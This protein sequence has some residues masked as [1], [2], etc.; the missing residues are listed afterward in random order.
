MARVP[1]PLLSAQIRVRRGL[2]SY[3]GKTIVKEVAVYAVSIGVYPF[4]RK[5]LFDIGGFFQ[6]Y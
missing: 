1:P 2:R 5:D 3:K 6:I 4:I